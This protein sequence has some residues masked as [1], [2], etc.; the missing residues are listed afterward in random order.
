VDDYKKRRN[1]M[2]TASIAQ[3]VIRITGLAQLIL[4]VIIWPGKSDSLIPVHILIGALL[5]IALLT[6]SF[7]AAR[8]GI[9]IGLII[10]TVVWALVLPAWGLIQEKL[11]PETGHWIIQ[12]LHLLCG[13]GAIGI[14]EM[15]SAQ[16]RKKR[17]LPAH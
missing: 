17:P 5:V 15:L 2:K 10:L 7:L 12:V 1:F 8:S 13:I 3:M 16:M 14:A 9:S 4:G 11:L 6:L